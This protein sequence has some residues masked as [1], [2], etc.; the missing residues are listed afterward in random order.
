VSGY[1]EKWSAHALSSKKIRRSQAANS[2]GFRTQALTQP[3]HSRNK[4]ATMSIERARYDAGGGQTVV[5]V[6][7]P[8]RRTA[9]ARL[10][11]W[12]FSAVIERVLFC[13]GERSSGA[14]YR[15]LERCSLSRATLLCNKKAVTDGLCTQ[16]EL[17]ELLSLL[18]EG[19]EAEHRGRVRCVSLLP[20]VHIKTL[21]TSL[22]RSATTVRLLEAMSTPLPQLWSMQMQQEEDAANGEVDLLLEDDVA[23]LEEAEGDFAAELA[24]VY[25]PYDEAEEEV[26][27]PPNWKLPRVPD[28]LVKELEAFSLH[29]TDPLVRAREGTACVDITVRRSL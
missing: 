15:L 7:F 5:V 23:E 16:A 17:E 19:I 28:A 10:E 27:A 9:N 1:N 26:A 6:Q 25:V 22:G 3:L 18:R 2:I 20:V 21:C 12:A 11:T 4:D 8:D 14:L 13:G 29:R 24:A